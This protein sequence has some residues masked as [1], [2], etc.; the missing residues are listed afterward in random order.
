MSLGEFDTAV[1]YRLPIVFVVY[2]DEAYGAEMHFLR[3]LGRPDRESL[4]SVPPLDQVARA[5]GGEG[6]AVETLADLEPLADRLRTLDG[7]ILLDC[8]ISRDVRA[9]WL[10][11]AFERGTH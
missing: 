6:M 11:E 2:N 1:R 3:M 7:P 10:E 5:L 9:V 8:R 4:F